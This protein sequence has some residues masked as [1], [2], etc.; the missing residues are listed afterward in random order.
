MSH[1]HKFKIA[2]TER[3]LSQSVAMVPGFDA[4][5]ASIALEDLAKY[6]H[7]LLEQ[8]WRKEFHRV[9]VIFYSDACHLTYELSG[10]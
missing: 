4:R 3:V 5:E 2:E 9:K 10:V 6:A 7:N 1:F 8:P